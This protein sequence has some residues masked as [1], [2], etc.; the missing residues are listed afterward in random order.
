MTQDTR[1][2]WN[3]IWAT[4]DESSPDPDNVLITET[5]G[6][7]PGRALDFGCGEGGNAVWL[8]EHGWQV[9][10]MD[11]AEAAIEKGRRLATQRKVDVDFFVADAATYQ[12]KGQYDLIT[13]F[14]LHLPVEQRAKMLATAATAL[15]PRGTLLFVGHDRSSPPPEWAEED[16]LTLTTPDE[17]ASEV[18][19]LK[20]E[21]A[22]VLDHGMD[23]PHGAHSHGADRPRDSHGHDIDEPNDSHRS[24][25]TIVRA[26]RPGLE[27]SHSGS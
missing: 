20:I 17:V 24:R 13:F 25:S 8:A 11:F 3:N 12:P 19:G 6:L 21:R 16:W 2:F 18:T 15:S 14:Y 9:T 23:D 5:E 22:F 26:V 10:A 1:E 4:I 7:T 27:P